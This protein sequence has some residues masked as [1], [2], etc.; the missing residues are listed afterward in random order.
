LEKEEE[1]E[2]LKKDYFLGD[3]FFEKRMLGGLTVG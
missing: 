2:V 1:V 3:Y